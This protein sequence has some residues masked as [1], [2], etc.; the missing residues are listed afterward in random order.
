VNANDATLTALA[1]AQTGSMVAD[2]TPNAPAN[3]S[4]DLIL[5]AAGRRIG[6]VVVTLPDK[7]DRPGAP[8]GHRPGGCARWRPRRP[9]GV[10]RPD[11]TRQP[12][13]WRTF[14]HACSCTGWHVHHS[15]R[16]WSARRRTWLGDLPNAELVVFGNSV[17][18][19]FAGQQ[20]RFLAAV[21]RFLA[22]SRLTSRYMDMTRAHAAFTAAGRGRSR[23][24]AGL[25][26]DRRGG[27]GLMRRIW[28]CLA[29]KP[30]PWL[31]T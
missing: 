27:Q 31:E 2:N 5:Q 14:P 22:A 11:L 6:S 30:K 7:P 9:A 26:R 12:A 28:P 8:P 10:C 23:A 18:M 16:V 24:A 29:P 21:R 17:R 1:S 15:Q 25:A 4:F 3:S 19:M 13:E 20:D